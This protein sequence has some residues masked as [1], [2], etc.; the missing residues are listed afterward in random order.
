MNRSPLLVLF[1][2]K[3]A[4]LPIPPEIDKTAWTLA[5]DPIFTPLST[6]EERIVFPLPAAV[7][8]KLPVPPLVTVSAPLSAI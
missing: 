5:V 3:E 2:I 1:T 4:L 8:V 7:N 6:S